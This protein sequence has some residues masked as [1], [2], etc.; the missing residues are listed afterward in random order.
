MRSSLHSAASKRSVSQKDP[1]QKPKV[2]RA[3]IVSFSSRNFLFPQQKLTFSAAEKIRTQT[4]PFLFLQKWLKNSLLEHSM[5]CLDATG[6]WGGA[7]SLPPCASEVGEGVEED[8]R[9]SRMRFLR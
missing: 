2:S 8:S 5:G 7:Q 3:E 9:A 1:Q 4:K 6:A